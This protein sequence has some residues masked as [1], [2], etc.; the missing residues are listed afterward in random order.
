MNYF[1]LGNHSTTY[2]KSSC[3]ILFIHVVIFVD[4]SSV[5]K[6]QS[7]RCGVVSVEASSTGLGS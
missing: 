4:Y 5:K 6:S 2:I 1:D 7:I 3:C